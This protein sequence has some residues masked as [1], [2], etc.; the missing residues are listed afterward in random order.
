MN[1]TRNRSINQCHPQNGWL[2]N[3]W[4]ENGWFELGLYTT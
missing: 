3:G 1:Q 4:L 2:E